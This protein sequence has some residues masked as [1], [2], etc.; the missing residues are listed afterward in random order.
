MPAPRPIRFAVL[1]AL[2]SGIALHGEVRVLKN[3]TLIDG[4][5]RA[6]LSQAAMVIDNGRVSWIGP[7]SQLKAPQ[8][9][10]TTDLSGKFVIPGIIDAHVHLGATIDLVQDAKNQTRENLEKNL[11]AYA[12][13]GVTTVLSLGTDP[14]VIFQIRAAQRAGRPAFARVYTAGQGFVYKNGYGGLAGVNK[15]V[16]GIAEIEPEVAAQ[17]AKKVDVIKLWM[18]DELGNYPKMPYE[19]SQAIIASAHRHGLR[20]LAH[21]FYLADAK[22]LTEQGVNGFV[23][24]VRD[25]PVD[26][27]LLDAMKKRGVWQVAATLSREE[28]MFAY[29]QTPA[30]I[31]DPFFVRAASPA[32]IRLLSSPEHQKTIAASPFYGRYPA[33]FETAKKNFKALAD[34]GINYSMGTDTGP[35]GRFAGYGDHWEMQAMVD[36]GLTPM[37]VIV[38]ATRSGAEFLGAKDLGTL[39]KSKWADLVVLNANPLDNIRNTRTINAVYI[40]GKPVQSSGGH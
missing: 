10:D 32:A 40:A 1:T 34:A 39:E 23:H 5:G 28:S 3:F 2:F 15:Q 30:F 38:A 31:N 18:D 11:Q 8:G 35:P 24:T 4:T 19:M 12:S 36:A 7:V 27:S 25:A 13:Y 21:V 22:K 26:Q 6:P 9:A 33:F 17:A 37:Q 20:T 29:G 14:D 16:S